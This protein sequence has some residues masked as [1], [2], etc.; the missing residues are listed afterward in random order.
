MT[1]S[2][3]LVFVVDDDVAVLTALERL[4]RGAGYGVR[5]FSSPREF[6]RQHDPALPGCAVL[7]IVMDGLSGLEVQR[8]LT[9]SGCC[10]ALI[11]LTGFGDIPMSVRAMRDGAVD[12][13]TKPV[14]AGD[15]LAAIRLAVE[16]DGKSRQV[17]AE[18]ECTQRRIAALTRREAEVLQHVIAGRLNKQIAAELGTAVKT[19]KVH[20]AR[21][22]DKMGAKSVANLVRMTEQAGIKP[23]AMR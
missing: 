10:R 6:L 9:E 1:A 11:F 7:D 5:G 13:L 18:V 21:V 4:L 22:M 23:A 14:D 2:S 19:I 8:T 12:F 20:R 15:F 3:P 17:G 16:R